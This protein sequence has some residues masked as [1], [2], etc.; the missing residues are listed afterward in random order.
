MPGLID[1]SSDAESDYDYDQE[2]VGDQGSDDE[3]CES[4]PE[5]TILLKKAAVFRDLM[6]SQFSND[7]NRK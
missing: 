2:I 3:K 6:D 5:H 4:S 1:T 7:G